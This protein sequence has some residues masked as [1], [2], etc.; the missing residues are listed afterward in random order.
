MNP[1][2]HLKLVTAIALGGALTLAVSPAQ[3]DNF[4][5]RIGSGH[6]AKT[7]GYV[8]QM[9]EY[10]V[11]E[12]TRRVAEETDHSVRFI[13]AYAGTVASVAETLEAVENGTL[14]IGGWCVCFEPTKALALNITYFLPFTTP[15]VRVAIPVLK[16]LVEEFPEIAADLPD[17][18]KQDL[19]GIAGFDNYGLGTSF[20]WQST[21]DL[22]GHKIL[23]AGPNLPW[24]QNTGAVPVTTTLP[25]A[26]EQLS[27]G[28]GEGIIIFPGTYF[29]FKFF[30]PAPFFTITNFGA[31]AQIAL[32]MNQATRAKLPADV[33]AIIDEVAVEWEGVTG[34][35]NKRMEDEGV[36]KLRDAGATVR[37]LPAQAQSEWAVA[38]QEWPAERASFIQENTGIDGHRIMR[39]YIELLEDTGHK[40]P[41]DYAQFLAN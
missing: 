23:A 33:L 17:K 30:E 39:R 36:Q 5:L 11:P 41:V 19:I 34:D 7:V 10:F 13:E 29:G 6:N 3:A 18:Y 9:K 4:I 2:T 24:L 1:G 22:Q 28:V 15:D 21:A 38:L 37:E 20:D 40:F 27:T 26:F 12:V 31:M 35:F 25:T 16:Q 32:T 14:D 8:K